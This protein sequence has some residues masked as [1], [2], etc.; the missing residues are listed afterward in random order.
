MPSPKT[1]GLPPGSVNLSINVQKSFR[2]QLQAHADSQDIKLSKWCREMLKQAYAEGW[3][4]T[5]TRSPTAA[6]RLRSSPL[7][8]PQQGTQ[9]ASGE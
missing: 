9:N 4:I 2:D 5:E 8:K 6:V 7:R 1:N 3:T